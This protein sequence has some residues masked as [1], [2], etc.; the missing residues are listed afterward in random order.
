MQPKIHPRCARFAGAIALAIGLAVPAAADLT[1]SA[2]TQI[3]PVGPLGLGRYVPLRL[4]VD[5]ASPDFN[6][7]ASIE[8][9]LPSCCTVVS[10]DYDDSPSGGDW[11]FD[12]VGVP[13]SEVAYVDA[14]GDEWGEI[15]AGDYGY[16]DL[17]VHVDPGCPSAARL[18]YDLY[19][20]GF[21]AEPHELLNRWIM[22][23][24]DEVAT[25]PASWSA[26]KSR[27]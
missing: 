5:N 23:T 6:W 18:Y 17:L 3:V 25:A 13:G 15:P 12:F 4:R 11:N 20:D 22:L 19:G 8:L 16:L 26:V 24:F 21:G 10:M 9:R 27:Y 1:G 7:I 14:A 2:L